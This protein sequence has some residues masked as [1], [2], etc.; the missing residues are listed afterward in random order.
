MKRDDNPRPPSTPARARLP[1]PIDRA[2]VSL[3]LPPA[4]R[5]GRCNSR[6]RN[7]VVMCSVFNAQCSTFGPAGNP[8]IDGNARLTLAFIVSSPSPA[9]ARAWDHAP[10]ANY[11]PPRSEPRLASISRRAS[12]SNRPSYRSVPRDATPSSRLSLRASSSSCP[13]GPCA[14]PAGAPPPVSNG[15]SEAGT[16]AARSRR[17]EP[18]RQ[19]TVGDA[20]PSDCFKRA[21]VVAAATRSPSSG[22]RRAS[23]NSRR[24]PRK[25]VWR[26][27]RRAACPSLNPIPLS[28]RI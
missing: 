24:P 10:T 26:A 23:R 12:R 17:K 3:L 21:A 1:A 7:S 15:S 4:L 16:R 9:A 2:L 18:S 20:S 28:P 6:A 14:H 22:T 27:S 5:R 25:L 19:A 13:F 11:R 8:A